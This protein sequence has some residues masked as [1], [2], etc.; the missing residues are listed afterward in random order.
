MAPAELRELKAQLQELLDKGFI[1]PSV[2]PW[3][4]PVLFVKKK[5]GSMRLCID[6]RELNRVTVRNKHPLP[7]IED[8]FD[9]LQG[10]QVF[11]KID[12]CFRYHR[13]HQLNIKTT[14]VPKTAFLTRYG[15]YEFLVM[16]FGLTNAPATFMDVMNRV[17]KTLLDK[18][19]VVL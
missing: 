19:V 10:A 5:D 4:A 14:D 2:S 11:S 7:R 12:L 6:Y 16:P 1:R 8:L 3:G 18:F 13:Y 15:H 9:Q 17:F